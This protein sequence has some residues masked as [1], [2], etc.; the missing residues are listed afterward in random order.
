MVQS[1]DGLSSD[2]DDDLILQLELRSAKTA[3]QLPAKSAQT[4]QQPPLASSAKNFKDEMI[5]AQGEASM[6]RDKIF[7]LQ[8][9]IKRENELQSLKAEE[10]NSV[11]HEELKKVKLALQNLEDE[12][13][14]LLLEVKKANSS[15]RSRGN[16]S[17]PYSNADRS[18]S[19]SADEVTATE[20]TRNRVIAPINKKRKIDNESLLKHYV[21]L[22]PGKIPR[23]ETSDFVDYLLLHKLVGSELS[24]IEILHSLELRYIA[25]FNFNGFKISRGD[26]IGKSLVT[27]LLKCKKCLTLDKFINTLL[28]SVAI[29]IKEIS[30]HKHESDL[31]IPFLV[32]IMYQTISF[33]PSAVHP[34]ALKDL[35]HFISDLIKAYQ[36]VL[37]QSMFENDPG[38]SAEPQIFQ[39]ELIDFLT[40]LYSFDTLETSL[41]I[42]RYLPSAVHEEVLDSDLLESLKQICKCALTISYT[43]IMNIVFNAI[44]ILNAL[45]NMMVSGKSSLTIIESQWW[46]NCIPRLYHILS[47]G[48]KSVNILSENDGNDFSLSRFHDC[49]GLIRNLGTNFIGKFISKLIFNDRLQSL[50]R[51]ISKDDIPERNEEPFNVDLKL[52]RWFLQ[53]KDDSLNLVENLMILYP[54]ESGIIDGE[55]LIQLTKLMS[56]EQENLIERYV[57]QDSDNL[58]FRCHL[59][60]H[61][62]T[63]IFWLCTEYEKQLSIDHIKEIESEL[64]MSLWR[65]IVTEENNSFEN[66]ELADHSQ[67]VD[68]LH[69]LELQDEISYYNDALEDMPGFIKQE[70]K[71]EVHDR[72]AK[73]MQIKYDE[74]HQHMARTI[75]ESKFESMISMEDIDSLYFAMGL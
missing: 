16:S 12:K 21:T 26:S 32:V 17:F 6:L 20:N 68:R 27:L 56:K 59:I 54:K 57:G 63:I 43:P 60:E 13:K 30:L 22:N 29:L 51:V 61:L 3:T 31:A 62:L 55:M 53:L 8:K 1:K 71:E 2:E 41:R 74:C 38:T 33:R 4:L 7:F 70:L 5:V 18:T 25:N 72:A 69:Q 14:F 9:Q 39:Y 19:G 47:R 40:T 75:L 15:T 66:S 49:F 44:A 58:Y 36:H 23:D 73:I 52:E 46:K 42:L 65:V 64:I 10:L 45:C 35:L 67:L 28:E 50:P 34:M 11:H 24:T 48:V 37:K